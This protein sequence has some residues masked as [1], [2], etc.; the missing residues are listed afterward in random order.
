MAPGA[1]GPPCATEGY[2]SSACFNPTL[3]AS[4]GLA[5]I[6]RGAA[7]LG[8]TVRISDGGAV[9]E[10]DICRPVIYDPESARLKS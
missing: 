3:Q 4:I 10:A 8:E 2:V 1:S 5:L 7:R 9:V 6:E